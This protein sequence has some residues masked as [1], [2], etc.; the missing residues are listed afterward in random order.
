MDAIQNLDAV[1]VSIISENVPVTEA[2]AV[3]IIT[4]DKL[5]AV[6]AD[7]IILDASSTTVLCMETSE[8]KLMNFIYNPSKVISSNK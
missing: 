3:D 7:T 6:P 5:I 8:G 1:P 2:T 4:P